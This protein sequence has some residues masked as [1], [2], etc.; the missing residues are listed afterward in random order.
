MNISSIISSQPSLFL[1]PDAHHLYPVH[2][3]YSIDDH[4]GKM[5]NTKC[6]LVERKSHDAQNLRENQKLPGAKS[7]VSKIPVQ[8]CRNIPKLKPLCDKQEIQHS[9]VGMC[10]F[11]IF[12]PKG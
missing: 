7:L 8:Y 6:H 9:L 4:H 11:A 1:G 2:A 12:I 5:M 10:N 3:T